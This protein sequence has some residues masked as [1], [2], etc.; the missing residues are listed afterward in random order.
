L[1]RLILLNFLIWAFN[2]SDDFYRKSEWQSLIRTELSMTDVQ[3][4]KFAEMKD[5]I[6]RVKRE[7]TLIQSKLRLVGEELKDHLSNRE[8]GVHDLLSMLSPLQVAK[9]SVWVDKNS[10]VMDVS[11]PSG[12]SCAI[13]P[14][15]LLPPSSS[16]GSRSG[17]SLNI[18]SMLTDGMIDTNTSDD[19]PMDLFPGVTSSG[20]FSH[21]NIKSNSGFLFGSSPS[22]SSISDSIDRDLF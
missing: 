6:Q 2:Q 8:K 15:Y 19:D 1:V 3:V 14:S 11:S 16:S 5:S 10:Q 13:L 18:S 9:L 7:G 21:H 17:S 4:R 20:P 12:Q 22:L